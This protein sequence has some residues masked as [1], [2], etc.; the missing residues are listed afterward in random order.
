MWFHEPRYE[1]KSQKVPSVPGKFALPTM[2]FNLP[3]NRREEPRF[4]ERSH[5]RCRTSGIDPFT[6]L[7]WYSLP[8]AEVIGIESYL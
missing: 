4:T 8:I 6:G 5:V 3:G 2:R 7:R 1:L